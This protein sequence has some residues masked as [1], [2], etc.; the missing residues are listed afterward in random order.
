M[1]HP[2]CSLVDTFG[3]A[4][5]RAVYNTPMVH[6]HRY[7]ILAQADL[8]RRSLFWDSQ[9]RI[10]NIN[11]RSSVDL[12]M[13]SD[14]IAMFPE[15][16]IVLNDPDQL[17]LDSSKSLCSGIASHLEF[18][19]GEISYLAQTGRQ[20][21]GPLASY[22]EHPDR[23]FH[24]IVT[25]SAFGLLSDK[26]FVDLARDLYALLLPG[27]VL[28][29]SVTA[30]EAATHEFREHFLNWSLR[31]RSQAELRTL[32]DVAFEDVGGAQDAHPPLVKFCHDFTLSAWFVYLV[33]P[34]VDADKRKKVMD[35]LE[36]HW[37]HFAAQA[38]LNL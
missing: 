12:Q 19:T 28:M 31:M 33:K 34:Q 5:D 11:C 29:V 1:L 8:I 15:T 18:V 24:V 38:E 30:R 26:A 16:R 14:V 22:F 6:Q 7:K 20:G 9:V 32:F 10:M 3:Q 27:G 21:H 23:R 4:L 17:A 25:G 2:Q 37:L 35:S 13:N 36:K